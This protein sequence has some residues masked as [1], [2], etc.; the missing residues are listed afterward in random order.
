M[1]YWGW[2]EVPAHPLLVNGD[3]PKRAKR[4]PRFIPDDELGRLMQAV[5]RLDDPFK[6]AAILVAP[7]PAQRQHLSVS[8]WV[9]GVN[10]GTTRADVSVS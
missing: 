6:R 10:Y 5:E 3:L 9:G 4:V 8:I 7:G 1:A 2:D